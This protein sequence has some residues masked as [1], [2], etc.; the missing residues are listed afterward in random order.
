MRTPEQMARKYG[1][2]A[3]SRAPVARAMAAA[4]Q[5]RGVEQV[6]EELVVDDD[7]LVRGVAAGVLAVDLRVHRALTGRSDLPAALPRGVAPETAVQAESAYVADIAAFMTTDAREREER[8]IRDLVGRV[9]T[10]ERYAR[11]K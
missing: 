9:G 1:R 3:D 7:R 11:R 10:L 4:I 8:R 5:E 6:F 2:R